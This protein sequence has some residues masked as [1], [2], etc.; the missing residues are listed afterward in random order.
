MMRGKSTQV[1]ES[2]KQLQRPG[3]LEFLGAA[4][5]T[6]D[7]L[8]LDDHLQALHDLGR[9]HPSDLDFA[10]IVVRQAVPPKR[11]HQDVG[12]CDRVLDGKVDPD[13]TDG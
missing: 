2:A 3:E 5:D 7:D 6:S 12:R 13:S 9:K 10:E 1:R 8:I 4:D 11:I